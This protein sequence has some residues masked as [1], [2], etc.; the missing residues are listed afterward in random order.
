MASGAN[1]VR[2][3][4]LLGDPRLPDSTKHNSRFGDE[5]LRMRELMAE[6]LGTLEGYAFTFFDDHARFVEAMTGDPPDHVLN[7]CDTGFR[8][9]ALREL[10]IPALLELIGV[11]YTGAP[12]AAMVLA[13]DKAIVR[14]LA[15]RLGIAVPQE[16]VIEVDAPL[17]LPDGGYPCLI[18]PATADGSVGIT[19]DAVVADK[20]AAEAYAARLRRDLPD[21]AILV[22]EF[23]PGTE[24]G[25]GMIGNPGDSLVAL[26]P[27]EVDYTRLDPGLPRLLGFESKAV[28]DSPYYSD[29]SYRRADLD[30]ATIGRLEGWCRRLFRRL[31]LRDYGRFDFRTDAGGTIK[32]M[33]VNPNPAW[34][35]DAKLAIMAG[36]AGWT[37]P[38]LLRNILDTSIR[39]AAREGG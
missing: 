4:V 8:N 38:E 27:M 11:P 22:Q 33:E 19:Q 24:Y 6:A 20:A 2:V 25:I 34:S 31:G 30:E 23:L 17:V 39:R 29:I 35:I 28:P 21:K 12:P 26:P 15:E 36:F 37:Y 32:L 18:K 3:T 1:P 5:D 10:H 9:N 7:F 13:Y 14:L 16:S